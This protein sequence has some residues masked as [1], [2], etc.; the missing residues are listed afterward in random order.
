[1]LLN[2]SIE[3]ETVGE[4]SSREVDPSSLPGIALFIKQCNAL[5]E[6]LSLPKGKFTESSEDVEGAYPNCIWYATVIMQTDES[7]SLLDAN[8]LLNTV[9]SFCLFHHYK[10]SKASATTVGE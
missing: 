1:M 2:L 3:I 10:L 5:S 4:E 9:Q 7:L 6:S 8:R